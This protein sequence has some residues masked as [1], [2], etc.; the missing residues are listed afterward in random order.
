MIHCLYPKLCALAEQTNITTII[1]CN[2]DGSKLGLT[3]NSL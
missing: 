1:F 3:L 2:G